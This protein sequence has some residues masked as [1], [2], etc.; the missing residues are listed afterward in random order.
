M[1]KN[2]VICGGE[3]DFQS[4]SLPLRHKVEESEIL[5]AENPDFG[6]LKHRKNVLCIVGNC[7]ILLGI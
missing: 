1:V 5:N 6:V 7:Q 3:S 4:V 2:R